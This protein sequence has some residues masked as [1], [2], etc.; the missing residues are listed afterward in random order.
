MEVAP[1]AFRD[2]CDQAKLQ[3]G[4]QVERPEKEL[5]GALDGRRNSIGSRDGAH[6]SP[7]QGR[8]R[9]PPEYADPIREVPP[10]IAEMHPTTSRRR[11]ARARTAC[12]GALSCRGLS[13]AHP[14]PAVPADRM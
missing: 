1:K 14:L 7:F 11:P 9:I 2:H 8:Q 13:C 12:D 4:S 6:L 10:P 5:P 3:I